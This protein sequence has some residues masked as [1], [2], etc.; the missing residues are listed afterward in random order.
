MDTA[1]EHSTLL[2]EMLNRPSN[3]I[4][5]LFA[6]THDYTA[7]DIALIENMQK[8]L[9]SLR[10]TLFRYASE[11]AE[12]QDGSLGEI[13]NLNDQ[14][15][16]ALQLYNEKIPIQKAEAVAKLT[17]F[18]NIE[19]NTLSADFYSNSTNSGDVALLSILSRNNSPAVARKEYESR[20]ANEL[21]IFE[22]DFR[23]SPPKI[24]SLIDELNSLNFEQ[25]PAFTMKQV[26]FYANFS[27]L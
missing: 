19:S 27:I 14:I 24:A 11:A 4:D 22:N 21:D 18:P 2:Q 23:N 15:N 1:S 17:S 25:L 6:S 5:E 20:S 10:P 3:S 26:N 8:S 9:L 12:A 13:L 16:K 7:E